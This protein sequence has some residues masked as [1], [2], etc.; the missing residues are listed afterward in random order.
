MICS[1][2]RAAGAAMALAALAP[3]LV[4]G[5]ASAQAQPAG[6][7]AQAPAAAADWGAIAGTVAITS[8]YVFRGV[9]QTQG[10]PALQ[11]GLEYTKEF[12]MFTP[13][14]GTFLSN[15]DFPDTVNNTDLKIDYELDLYFGLRLAPLEALTLDAGYIKYY[16]PSEN[17]PANNSLSFNWSEVYLKGSYDFGVAKTTLGWWHSPNYSAGAGKGNYFAANVDVPLPWELTAS[18][19]IG[20]LNIENE[21]NFGLPDYT[22]W[23]LGVSRAFDLLWGSTVALTYSDTNVSRTSTLTNR[24]DGVSGTV[25]NR[26]YNLASPRV[27]LSVTKSF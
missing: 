23:S 10:G 27:F 8:D 15:A 24:S 16:Y 2:V 22:D 20:R 11:G 12:G 14:A 5:P 4:S 1:S 13:Y 3:I 26:F 6:P 7:Q 18:G 21:A 19:H 17:A 9:S 25:D